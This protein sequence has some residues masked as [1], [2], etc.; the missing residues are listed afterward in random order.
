MMSIEYIAS[1]NEVDYQAFRMIVTTTL[2]TDYDMWL[3]VRERGKLRAQRERG[4]KVIEIELSPMEFGVY[5]RAAKRP[6][7]SIVGLDRCAREK[8]E[9]QLREASLGRT[10]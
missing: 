2:P 7:F 10:A 6:D 3:R 5:F 4:A 9:F 1:I 8:A